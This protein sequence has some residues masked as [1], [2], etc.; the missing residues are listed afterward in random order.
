MPTD[1]FKWI[2]INLKVLDTINDNRS[3]IG[4]TEV[5]DT[6]HGKS[7]NAL[8]PRSSSA[9][10]NA[11]DWSA[12]STSKPRNARSASACIPCAVAL[13]R[14]PCW[15]GDIVIHLLPRPTHPLTTKLFVT[16]LGSVASHCQDGEEYGVKLVAV[17][18][19]VR[20]VGPA[21]QRTEGGCCTCL[22]VFGLHSLLWQHWNY[23]LGPKG[24]CFHPTSNPTQLPQLFNAFTAPT[25]VSDL[26]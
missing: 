10:N 18:A 21:L 11:S 2:E 20:G 6:L 19:R 15:Y 26:Q 17:H 14:T 24:H 22:F 7:G 5:V 9:G 23:A 16:H 25:C 12:D 1:T 3:I 8:Q 4:S 13:W